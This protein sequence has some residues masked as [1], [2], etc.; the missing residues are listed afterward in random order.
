MSNPENLSLEQLQE[1]IKASI[2]QIENG[3][4]IPLEDVRKHIADR[5]T[6]ENS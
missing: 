2:K 5:R 4:S 6:K 1:K 3:E